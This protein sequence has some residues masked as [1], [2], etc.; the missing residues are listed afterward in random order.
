MSKRTGVLVICYISVHSLIFKLIEQ[1][2]KCTLESCVL[3]CITNYL[4]ALVA[5]AS[6][7]RV[8]SQEY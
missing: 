4:H 3:S 7:I 1:T 5:T 2:D 8:P 6:T